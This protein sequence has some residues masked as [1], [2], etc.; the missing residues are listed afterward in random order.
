MQS[1]S[2]IGSICFLTF[3]HVYFV[4]GVL[5]DD[6]LTVKPG[7]PLNMEISLDTESADIYGV[8][9]SKME[10]T[11]TRAQSEILVLNG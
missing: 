3:I 8:M 2:S 6:E 5:I 10:V 9:V 7:T 11:D 1:P 4:S